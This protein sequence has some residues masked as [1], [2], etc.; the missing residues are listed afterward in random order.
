MRA[1]PPPFLAVLSRPSRVLRVLRVRESVF[2]DSHNVAPMT[3][4]QEPAVSGAPVRRFKDRAYVEVAPTLGELRTRIDALDE[5]IV[6]LM[7]Q[8]AACVR[9]A[10]RFKRDAFQVAAPARQ[11]QVFER[12]RALAAAR[13]DTFPGFA[14]IVEATYRAMVAGFVAAEGQ[15]FNET[16]T[17][18]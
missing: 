16:E 3:T 15:L 10:T 6:A 5:R 11:A 17:I 9:D 12:V 4:P 2:P 13:G 7:A 8:R 1:T 14:D 18:T